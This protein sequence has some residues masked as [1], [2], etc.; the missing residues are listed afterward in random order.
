[1]LAYDQEVN[2]ALGS[3]ISSSLGAE[4]D[5]TDQIL[6]PHGVQEA[7]KVLHIPDKH[8]WQHW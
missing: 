4:Q 6:S 5:D 8:C 7:Q 3:G 2:I 1:M